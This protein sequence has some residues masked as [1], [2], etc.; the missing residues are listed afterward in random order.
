[1]LQ[2]RAQLRMVVGMKTKT[3]TVISIFFLQYISFLSK[4]N[5]MHKHDNIV[6]K[7]VK[8]TLNN[9]LHFSNYTLL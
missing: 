8:I 1:M 9:N 2:G 7:A 5:K 4:I 3:G 6:L